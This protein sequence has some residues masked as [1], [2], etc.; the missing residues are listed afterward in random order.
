MHASQVE[1][2]Q[3]GKPFRGTRP[4]TVDYKDILTY[5]LKTMVLQVLYTVFS[6]LE[7]SFKHFVAR[8]KV[9]L[10]TSSQNV[11]APGTLD[12]LF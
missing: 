8:S 10:R 2:I 9:G 3:R 4:N 11:E 7:K 6:R 12:Y 1:S 5:F